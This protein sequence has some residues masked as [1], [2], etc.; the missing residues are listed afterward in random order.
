[1]RPP[2]K[3][4]VD[5][6]Y[7]HL[8]ALKDVQNDAT[9]LAI[10]RTIGALTVEGDLQP[11]VAKHNLRTGR[12][13]LLAYPDFFNSPFPA[14]VASW[15]FAPGATTSSSH[16]RYDDSLNPP[17]LHRKELMV[18][19]DCPG[20]DAWLRLTASAEGLGL[21]DD[22]TTIGFKLNWERLIASKGWRLDGDSFVPLGND[23]PTECRDSGSTTGPV[24]RHL[25]ALTRSNLSAPVQLLLRH[26]L[27]PEGTS[28]FDYGCG[29]GGD[30]AGLTANGFAAHGWDPHYAADQPTREADVVNLGFVVN[31]IED[32]AERVEALHKAF[33]LARRVMAVGVMLYGSETAGRP[34]RDGFITSRNTFQ[35]YFSQGEF[36][37]YLEQVLQQEAFMAGPGVAFVFSDKD[38]E[39]RFSVGRFRSRGIA[40]RV[41]ATRVPRVRLVR[42]P[43]LRPAKPPNPQTP[44]RADLLLL[45][46]RPQLDALWTTTLDLGRLPES[47]E[48]ANLADIEAQLGGLP[49]ALRLL[50]RHY[51]QQLL[52]AAARTRADDVRLYLAMQQFSK[53]PAYQQLEPRLQR[54]IKAFF[55]DYRSAQAAGLRLLLDAA[56][57]NQL[58]AACQRAATD[59]LGWL[60]NQHSLQLHVSMVERLPVLLRAYV[61]CGL[62]LW[63]AL[64][65]VQLVKI[66]IASGKLTLMELDDFDTSPLPL[67]RRRIKVNARKQD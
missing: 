39:Q 58:L 23:V 63:D 56:D 17:I 20:R 13:S 37:D 5:E 9:R 10:E 27:L 66:H 15:V 8:S 38:S 40:A 1:M 6:F 55:G 64:S 3:T 50:A 65:E 7:V 34:F 11:N 26:G 32:Q 61:A 35:K 46:A 59:G 2:G 47:D 57:P 48:V 16:R 62:I 12:V 18:A 41:L 60:E 49:K 51:D 4:I 22:T 21:F 19:H 24:Q 53:R 28:L 52:A 30:V 67:L 45:N 43:K 42:D 33:K 36:K 14:L 29:R 44:S 54:D 31:V 25:T